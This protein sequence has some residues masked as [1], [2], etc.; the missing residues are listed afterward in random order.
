MKSYA[1][2]ILMIF[3]LAGF[4]LLPRDAQA[5]MSIYCQFKWEENSSKN[6]KASY[7]IDDDG[8]FISRNTAVDKR[9]RLNEARRITN[10]GE[11]AVRV[12][13]AKGKTCILNHPENARIDIKIK[14]DNLKLR[15]GGPAPSCHEIKA[16]VKCTTQFSD[17]Y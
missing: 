16:V 3:S 15:Q 13:S 8:R 7:I 1:T 14:K 4:G 5:L 6:I 2:L 11:V 17:V 10:L 9:V 12:S